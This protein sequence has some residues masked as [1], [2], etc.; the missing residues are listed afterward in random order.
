MDEWRQ[1]VMKIGT[2]NRQGAVGFRDSVDF[3]WP[4]DSLMKQTLSGVETA[5]R[6]A[7]QLVEIKWTPY[8]NIPSCYGVYPKM[9]EET[10]IPYSLAY[11]TNTQVGTQVSLHTY[12]TA[13]QNP[14][15]VMYTENLSEP[16]YNGSSDSAP[17]YGTT[18]SNS[19]M[20]VLGIE[21]PYFTRMIGIIP[22]MKK[23]KDQSP[24][25][26]E[27]CDVLWKSG[28]VMMVYDIVRD[29]DDSISQVSIF[30]TSTFEQRDTW[31][32]ELSYD[33][34]VSYWNKSGIV[35]YQYAYLNG[36]T[37]YE[38]SLFV[39]L[40]D[41]TAYPFQYNYD[42]CPTLGDRCSYLEGKDVQLAVLSSF[43]QR[44]V[45]FKD[46]VEYCSVDAKRPITTIPDLPYGEYR[47][48]LVRDDLRSGFSN[49]EVIDAQ[50]ET[51]AGNQIQI[52]FDSK[53]ASARYISI[54]DECGRPYNYYA[55]KESER[56]GGAFS[57]KKINSDAATHY[58]VYFKG[59]YGVVAT[60][61]KP[62]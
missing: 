58:Q 48:C 59:R 41:E 45:L 23:T 12:M 44:I 29:R 28:H 61:V 4:A 30:E 36:N 10:G 16:P 47:A 11:M 1:N 55:L 2:N 20:Y 43:Y 18:C 22:G 19:V 60:D 27:L 25:S 26:I 37:D 54:C 31:F 62:L 15:S 39:P 8:A 40:E 52:R 50:A 34:F 6:R 57:M 21:P 3:D 42:L 53:N 56:E 9:Q 32:R 49:F 17:Y 14:Y 24:D 33:D 5:R 51:S 13:L 38:V 7:R 35:R 46:G